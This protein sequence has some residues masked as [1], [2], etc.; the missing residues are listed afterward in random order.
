MLGIPSWAS[1]MENK[2]L[3]VA[4]W[5]LLTL[6]SV[7]LTAERYSARYDKIDLDAILTNDRALGAIIRCILEKGPCSPEGKD[8]KTDLPDALRTQCAKCTDTQKRMIRKS[9]RYLLTN[10]PEDWKAITRKAY[11]TPKTKYNAM[12]LTKRA[13]P[14]W[15]MLTAWVSAQNGSSKYEYVDV[16]ALLSNH[17]TLNNYVNCVLDKGPCT[18]EGRDLKETFCTQCETAIMG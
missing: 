13:L 11:D 7:V 2:P 4:L 18:P 1:E 5:C 15:V 12:L 17:R 6:V 3:V 9:S 10:R 14:V 8:I 16:D